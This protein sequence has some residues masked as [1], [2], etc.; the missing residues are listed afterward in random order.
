MCYYS[1]ISSPLIEHIICIIFAEIYKN[2]VNIVP[3]TPRNWYFIRRYY[4]L[5]PI[6]WILLLISCGIICCLSS[7]FNKLRVCKQQKMNKNQF[8]PFDHSISIVQNKSY[9]KINVIFIIR[10][11]LNDTIRTLLSISREHFH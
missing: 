1:A 5:S 11:F 2:W 6:R 3:C 8:E 7:T 10:I 4:I 9:S